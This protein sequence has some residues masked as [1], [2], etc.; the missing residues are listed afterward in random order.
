[1]NR[2]RRPFFFALILAL[3]LAFSG[4]AVADGLTAAPLTAGTQSSN[5]MVRV[6]L[7]SLNN[8]ATLTFHAQSGYTI[9]GN[10]NANVSSGD[11]ITVNFAPETGNL[12]CSCNGVTAAMGS[13]FTIS[14]SF[15]VDGCMLISQSSYA[16]IPY[17]GDFLLTVSRGTTGYTLYVINYVYIETYLKGVLPY[18][19]SNSAGAEALKAQAVVARTYALKKMQGRASSLYDLVDTS[20]DQVYYGLPS[21]YDACNAA[22]DATAGMVLTYN[23]EVCSAYYSASNGG[24]TESAANAWGV[25]GYPY[26]AVKDDP[27]DLANPQSTVKTAFIPKNCNDSAVNAAFLSLLK[28]KSV[29]ALA[30]QGCA[31]TEENTVVNTVSSMVLTSPLYPAPSRIYTR[32]TVTAACTVEGVGQVNAI[33]SLDVFNE[34]ESILG[35]G[36]NSGKNELW[37]ILETNNGFSLQARRYGHGIGLSQRGAMQM[38]GAGIP[39]EQILGFYFTDCSRTKYAFTQG[40]LKNNAA[41]VTASPASLNADGKTV[42]GT[43]TVNGNGYINLR[44]GPSTSHS[45][46]RTVNNGT[47]VEILENGSDGWSLVRLGDTVAY[48][49]TSLLDSG[50]KPSGT[51]L[52]GTCS[53]SLPHTDETVN[54]RA[55]PSTGGQILARLRHGTSVTVLSDNNGWCKVTYATQTGYIM[56]KFLTSSGGSEPINPVTPVEPSEAFDAYVTLSGADSTVNFRRGPST[57]TDILMRLRN[58]TLVKVTRNDGTWSQVAYNGTSG[59]IMSRYLSAGVSPAPDPVSGEATVQTASGGLNLRRTGSSSAQVIKVIPRFATVQV[60]IYGDTW[61]K[62]SYNGVTGYVMTK[63]LAFSS[64][65]DTAWVLTGSGTLNLRADS[66]TECMILTTIPRLA[67]VTVL[68]RIGD[69]TKVSYNNYTGYVMTKFLTFVCPY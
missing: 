37:S 32:L 59:Y 31:A 65:S 11:T 30:S 35:L 13:S 6:L 26:L 18:E 3:L 47:V 20:S 33:V 19:M 21:G 60:L 36:I 23:G 15:S 62:V 14:R 42:I 17:A 38:S 27:Y 8:P 45:V 7:E 52:A 34:L 12:T 2:S 57:G 28:T 39:Y 16:S 46:I 64:T 68:I 10:L 67:P 5:G 56:T 1:M 48:A 69:W 53:V 25:S 43:A 9:G 55:K 22:V 50:D 29:S 63:F 58:G 49:M 51:G 24:Q 4:I 54:F 44:S 41:P 40:V 66:S 61:C